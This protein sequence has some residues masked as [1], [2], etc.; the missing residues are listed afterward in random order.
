MS[1]KDTHLPTLAVR[2][3]PWFGVYP[4]CLVLSWLWFWRCPF[5]SPS[6]SFWLQ[7]DFDWLPS[8]HP[9]KVISVWTVRSAGW[10]G[11]TDSWFV[12]RM[13]VSAP[14]SHHVV[15]SWI[16]QHVLSVLQK[17]TTLSRTTAEKHKS[18]FFKG[19]F[20]QSFKIFP[21]TARRGSICFAIYFQCLYDNK[22]PSWRK[23]IS[24][25]AFTTMKEKPYQRPCFE[26]STH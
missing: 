21:W 7:L 22:S 1:Y 12:C 3:R 23:T 9:A 6:A 16:S 8:Q 14:F 4:G 15:L 25:L 10:L 11:P 18:Q 13:I 19:E 26:R 20:C 5:S 2:G 17:S 24:N